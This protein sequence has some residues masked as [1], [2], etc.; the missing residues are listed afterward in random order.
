MNREQAIKYFEGR[1]EELSAYM[2]NITDP[3]EMQKVLNKYIK[4]YA[5]L[6]V[7]KEEE[8]C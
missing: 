3:C 8:E 1:L 2:I 6:K 7:L 4:F 5:L